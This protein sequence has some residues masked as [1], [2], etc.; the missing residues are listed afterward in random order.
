MIFVISKFQVSILSGIKDIVKRVKIECGNLQSAWPARPLGFRLRAWALKF[1][2]IILYQ[3]LDARNCFYE[4][5]FSNDNPTCQ[6]P[7]ENCSV[8]KFLPKKFKNG[9]KNFEVKLAA[10][11]AFEFKCAA[12]RAI[13]VD[14]RVTI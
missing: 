11:D 13:C 10:A 12:S 1:S 5:Q 7:L 2:F 8:G 6:L 9:S 14:L 4:I 3:I